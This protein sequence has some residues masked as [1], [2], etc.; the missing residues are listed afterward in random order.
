MD[1]P[2]ACF[3]AVRL[4]MS[5]LQNVKVLHFIHSSSFKKLRIEFSEKKFAIS[6]LSKNRPVNKHSVYLKTFLL[7]SRLPWESEHDR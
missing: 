7:M 1:F 4:Y 6:F 5:I 2:P 3:Q